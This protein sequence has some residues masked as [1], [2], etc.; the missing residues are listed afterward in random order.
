MQKRV[1]AHSRVAKL[2]KA[3]LALLGVILMLVIFRQSPELTER[4]YFSGLYQCFC[5]ILRPL[6]YISPFSLGDIFYLCAIVAVVAG[7]I[8][9]VRHWVTKQYQFFKEL[10]LKAFIVFEVLWLAFYCFW[11]LNYYRPA[12]AELLN[13]ADTS[14]RIQ[15]V[16]RVTALIIDSANAC[17][18]R[19]TAADLAD[20]SDNYYHS[21]VDAIKNLSSVSPKF[22]TVLPCLKPSVLSL[23]T[24][25]MGVSG[26]YNPFTSEAQINILMPSFDRPFVACHELSHQTGWAREDEANFAGYIAGTQ[27]KDKLLR[28]SSY[29]AGIEEFMRYL[30]FR[31]TV[32]HKALAKRISPLVIQDFKT[33]SAYWVKYQGGTAKGFGLFYNQFL[34]FNN[35]P[36]GLHTYNRMIRLT[37]AWYRRQYQVW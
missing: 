28:Y 26:Y 1:K 19:L 4:I 9:L 18:A 33:D 25:Y 36:H 17:R 23:V 32:A 6:T 3:A 15:D 24:S 35:Q 13:L 5:W 34:I 7:I 21:S 16:S 29:Y 2:T 27:S 12:V 31:D 14:Y 37:M 10:L 11:G 30:R 8:R 22:N 20:K